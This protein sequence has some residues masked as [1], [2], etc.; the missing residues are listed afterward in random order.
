MTVLFE[1]RKRANR[2]RFTILAAI[3]WSL[4]W[5]YWAN[6]LRSGGTRMGVVV[7]V[8]IVG[9]LPLVA[10][11]FY[12]NVYVIRVLRDGERL[13]LTTL[14]LFGKRERQIAIPSIV[15]VATP[16]AGVMTVRVK[17]QR[18]PYMLDLQAEYI[19]VNAISALTRDKAGKPQ[20][21]HAG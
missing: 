12:G 14:G 5:F 11:H 13:I 9:I 20:D 6:L 15:E 2:A 17:G 19:D 3:V 16:E 8:G 7:M 18:T 1:N 10:L 21:S 4:G